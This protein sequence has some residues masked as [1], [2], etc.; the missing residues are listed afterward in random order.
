MP[1]VTTGGGNNAYNSR[2]NGG[3][4]TGDEAIVDG[5]TTSEG[6]M[7]QSGMVG[8]QTDFGMS[9]DIT[10]EV[11]IW[12]PTTMHNMEIPPPA[13]SLSK[14]G[15]AAS[16]SMAADMSI[17]ATTSSMPTSTARPARALTRK[18]TMARLSA[19]PL[20]SRF[21][22]RHLPVER[23]LLLQLGRLPG[24]RRRCNRHLQSPRCNTGRQLQRRRSQLYY[25]YD[26]AKYGAQAGQPIPNNQIDPNFED[27][28][29]KV[30]L[31]KLPDPTNGQEV[32]NYFIPRS[33]QGSL[34]NSE[35]VYFF[36]IDVNVGQADH[37]YYTF[38]WQF[39]GVNAQTDLPIAISTAT[40][41]NPENA[42]I[43]RMNWEHNFN[44]R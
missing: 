25:P 32:N 30:F 1:G 21:S 2:T 28:I 34:T 31:S 24:S 27:P 36:R 15:A 44:S 13:S 35:N 4:I 6:Y 16:A 7:N 26:P 14:P 10:S 5:V 8:L 40:P 23:L 37:F 17:S 19:A 39:S 3:I 43:Q 42:P 38:W 20:D 9:P 12:P 18:T 29:T 41:A 11:K 33:G 22:Q